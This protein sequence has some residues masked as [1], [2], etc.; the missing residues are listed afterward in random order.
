[1]PRSICAD[2]PLAIYHEHPDW[3][4]PLF[5]ELERRSVP[6]IRLDAASHTY[7]PG[8]PD[9]P[10][11]L[12][13]NRASPSAYL[14]S[15]GQSTFYTLQWLRHLERLGVPVVNGSAAYSVDTSKALQLDI[16]TEPGQ[17][18]DY[19]I[20]YDRAANTVDWFVDGAQV[21]HEEEVPDKLDGF[22]V[23]MGLMT[24]PNT[25]NLEILPNVKG[26][27]GPDNV[28]RRNLETYFH[29][30]GVEIAAMP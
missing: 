22:I 20:T 11:G 25:I 5:A 29:S 6:Y 9:V 4:R 30:N 7:D 13:F 23:A 1:M 8:E 2:Q 24:R 18:H 27:P 21:N 28:R 17:R 16:L 3:F 14:R 19:G 26:V 12:V 15:H 10:Y